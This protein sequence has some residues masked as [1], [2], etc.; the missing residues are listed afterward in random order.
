MR[1]AEKAKKAVL[2]MLVNLAVSESEKGS[3][4]DIFQPEE[5]EELEQVRAKRKK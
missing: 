4:W 5:P 3:A 2:D 1:K